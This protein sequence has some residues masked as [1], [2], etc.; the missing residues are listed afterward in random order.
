MC[1]HHIVI[2]TDLSDDG[3]RLVEKGALLAEALQA[4]LAD[5]CGRSLRH[6]PRGDRL[7]GA[8]L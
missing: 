6:L 7:F 4:K 8:Q 3:K 2:A 1:Y 5:L